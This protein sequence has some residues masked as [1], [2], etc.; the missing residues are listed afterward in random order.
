MQKKIQDFGVVR[1]GE[2]H[3]TWYRCSRIFKNASGW[4]IS[5]REGVDVGP[6]SCEFDAE[7]DAESMVGQ[8]SNCQPEKSRQ[9]V[10]NQVRA[11]NVGDQRLDSQAY[12]SYL[13]EE[14]GIELLRRRG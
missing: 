8:L 6:Y 14:G 5:T 11:A 2:K 13:V 3:R 1:Q 12:T 9:V 4:F 7:V 10:F